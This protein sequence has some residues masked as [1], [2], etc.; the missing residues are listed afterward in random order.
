MNTLALNLINRTSLI[1]PGATLMFDLG[2]L[3]LKHA[4]N[5]PPSN[6]C[7][8]GRWL[9]Y[10][11]NGTFKHA[12]I[13]AAPPKSAECTVGWIAHYLIGIIFE[14]IFIAIEGNPWLQH[15]MLPA[16]IFGIG[17]VLA[18]LFILQ[19]SFVLGVSASKT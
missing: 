6:I 8:I 17:M 15:P 13:V 12:Y 1:G 7:L 4:F 5:V 10:M 9:R 11:P 3:L 18:L 19:P 16:I 2:G 14:F